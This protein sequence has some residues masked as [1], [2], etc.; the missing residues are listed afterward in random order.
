MSLLDGE[1]RSELARGTPEGWSRAQRRHRIVVLHEF[2]GFYNDV[3]NH[4]GRRL[5]EQMQAVANN[6]DGFAAALE[7]DGDLANSGM[8]SSARNAAT[9]A[10]SNEWAANLRATIDA[11]DRE[12]RSETRRTRA[13]A[14]GR[15]ERG[16]MDQ[17]SDVDEARDAAAGHHSNEHTPGRR[18]HRVDSARYRRPQKCSELAENARSPSGRRADHGVDG[19]HGGS[20]PARRTA[21]PAGCALPAGGCSDHRLAAARSSRA[22]WDA[23]LTLV[24]ETVGDE[25]V[26]LIG[27]TS[28]MIRKPRAGCR[29]RGPRA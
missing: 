19:R 1:V 2:G 8:I 17:C 24:A 12:L 7:E 16:G 10:Y 21:Q 18:A 11:L 28:T 4:V 14:T 9:T 29:D 20:E 15:A 3:D 25:Q 26:R 22:V 6:R 27:H 13:A 23:A 5:A